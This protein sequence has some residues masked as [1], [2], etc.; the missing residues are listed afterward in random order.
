[1]SP[2]DSPVEAP[3][4]LP[5]LQRYPALIIGAVVVIVNAI[6]TLG[7]AGSLDDGFQWNPDGYA[8]LVP[9]LGFVGLHT[10]VFSQR[11]VDEIEPSRNAQRRAVRRVKRT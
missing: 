10:Q 1:M 8:I 3:T 9:L 11:V 6:I 4:A 2:D 7:G 5:G